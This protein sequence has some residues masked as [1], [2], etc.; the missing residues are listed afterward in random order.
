M[1][2]LRPAAVHTPL[3]T[4]SPADPEFDPFWERVNEAGVTVIAHVSNSGYSTQGYPKGGTLATIGSGALRQRVLVGAH[5]R[6]GRIEAAEKALPRVLGVR[7]SID[8]E[9][10]QTLLWTDLARTPSDRSSRTT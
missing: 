4:R 8:L 10:N 9:A 5:D 3:G 7:S 1:V 6:L 2:A